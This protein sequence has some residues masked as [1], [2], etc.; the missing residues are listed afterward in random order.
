MKNF[1]TLQLI[2]K[3]IE[4]VSG[5][6]APVAEIVE[7]HGEEKA[8]IVLGHIYWNTCKM[9]SVTPK[10]IAGIESFID[11]KVAEEKEMAKYGL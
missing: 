2:A 3:N 9:F 4:L 10:R 7:E 11:E 6:V 8:V 5:R 1:Q